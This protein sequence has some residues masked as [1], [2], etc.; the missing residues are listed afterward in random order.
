[1]AKKRAA[2]KKGALATKTPNPGQINQIVKWALA[3]ATE[4]DLIEAIEKHYPRASPPALLNAA[5]KQLLDAGNSDHQAV[6]G[7]CTLATRDL[8][9]RCLETG[10][11]S[12]ALAALKNLAALAR[13]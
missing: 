5:A 8:Y 11:F 13:K 2:K 4:Q 12:V 9:R 3:G 1:M 6:I 7:F 10:D